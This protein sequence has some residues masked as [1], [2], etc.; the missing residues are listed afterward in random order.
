MRSP[1]DCLAMLTPVVGDCVA[2][3]SKAIRSVQLRDVE[4]HRV[5]FSPTPL[6]PAN[7][8]HERRFC[9]LMLMILDECRGKVGAPRAFTKE[10]WRGRAERFVVT[11]DGE[12]EREYVR[13][14]KNGKSGH[15]GGLAGRLGCCVRT[16]D[17]YLRIARAAGFLRI[18]QVKAKRGLDKLPKHLKGKKYSYAIFDWLTELPRAVIDRLTGRRSTAARE[19][20]RETAPDAPQSVAP[21]LESTSTARFM[22]IVDAAAHEPP[23]RPS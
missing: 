20:A 5:D 9:A 19:A 23:R 18:S 21:R 12:V 13:A 15:Q 14:V 8:E 6:H 16:V 1:L 10:L 7:T 11:E 17:R 3:W 2:R 4:E 22:A